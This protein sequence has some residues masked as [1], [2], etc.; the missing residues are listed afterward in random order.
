[1]IITIGH[2]APYEGLM[3]DDL[4]LEKDDPNH[5]KAMMEL[6][7]RD[8]DFFLIEFPEVSQKKVG[9]WFKYYKK[10]KDRLEQVKINRSVAAKKAAETRLKNKNE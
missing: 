7:A 9:K 5:V 2:Y 4:D 8:D 1:M 6:L 3:T 10:E